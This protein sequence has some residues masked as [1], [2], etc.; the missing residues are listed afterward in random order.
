MKTIKSKDKAYRYI[1]FFTNVYHEKVRVEFNTKQEL[2]DVLREIPVLRP[3][4]YLFK[5]AMLLE[6]HRKN[7]IV[8]TMK[9]MLDLNKNIT[10]VLKSDNEV[11][12]T[13]FL[14]QCVGN[15][16]DINPNMIEWQFIAGK[17]FYLNS[18]V[19]KLNKEH[20]EK[21]GF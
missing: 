12:K 15:A 14:V 8:G 13:G 7:S 18:R 5:K 3:P 20:K 2:R 10:V 17:G 21:R 4:V 16:Y 6:V 1:L 11:V 19:A 9:L